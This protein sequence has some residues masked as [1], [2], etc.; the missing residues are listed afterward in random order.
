MTGVQKDEPYNEFVE[1][2]HIGT[3]CKNA[4]VIL[5][6]DSRTGGASLSQFCFVEDFTFTYI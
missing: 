2:V 5:T 3:S 1:E 4:E 6:F